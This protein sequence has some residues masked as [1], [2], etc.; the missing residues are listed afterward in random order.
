MSSYD[1]GEH[2]TGHST[3]PK[4]KAEMLHD[5]EEQFEKTL[6]EYADDAIGDLEDEVQLAYDGDDIN[7]ILLA[8][9]WVGAGV[10]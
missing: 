8:C 4:D 5:I 2:G 3:L 7:I 1:E 9:F 6:E 10:R